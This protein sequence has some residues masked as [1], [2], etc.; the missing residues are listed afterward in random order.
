MLLVKI[1]LSVKFSL[2]EQALALGGS[3][4]VLFMLVIGCR[5]DGNEHVE[6][7]DLS[8]ESSAK[9]ENKVQEVLN[10]SYKP[11]FAGLVAE[12]R[13]Q[14]TIVVSNNEVIHAE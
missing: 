3:I 6:N 10:K 9:E 7:G 8:Q 12:L 14:V 13:R 2:K 4:N 1:V 11:L 5:H